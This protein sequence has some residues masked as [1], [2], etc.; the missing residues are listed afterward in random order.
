MV[1]ADLPLVVLALLF[2][3]LF[4]LRIYT[5]AYVTLDYH[6]YE[7]NKIEMT[8]YAPLLCS[9]YVGLCDYLSAP[10]IL[11]GF[12]NPFNI[13]KTLR[14]VMI[15][16][17]NSFI[18]TMIMTSNIKLEILWCIA[19]KTLA[20]FGNAFLFLLACLSL[21]ELP[22]F[23]HIYRN[24]LVQQH[25]ILKNSKLEANCRNLDVIDVYNDLV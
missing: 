9:F 7:G 3:I 22:L 17:K 4:P 23:F 1:F 19:L 10:L 24:G 14:I 25:K 20:D 12:L 5:F 2:S 18:N 11:A 6:H 21:F 16:N 15:Q 8:S 13:L